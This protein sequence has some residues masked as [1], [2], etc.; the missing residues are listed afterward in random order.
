V[1]VERQ[2]LDAWA[3]GD[4]G[5]RRARIDALA[6]VLFGDGAGPVPWDDA[7]RA[8]LALAAGP[9]GRDPDAVVDCPSCGER[10]EIVVPAA[11][12][13]SLPPGPAPARRVPTVADMATVATM[14]PADAGAYLARACGLASADDPERTGVLEALDAAHPLLAPSLAVVCP[15]CG[16]GADV[17]VDAVALAWSTLAVRAEASL[18]DVA[19]L[20]RAFGWSEA[21]VLAVPPVRRA[22]YRRLAEETSAGG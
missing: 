3:A 18:H 4:A 15:A 12:L 11:A 6:G 13:V 19:A 8:M 7:T 17:P 22:A 2:L 14:G 20:G 5:G 21:E 16:D 10:M 9:A 1:T